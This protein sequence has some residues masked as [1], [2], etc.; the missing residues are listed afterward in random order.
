MPTAFIF[1]NY[2]HL[3]S[4]G[5]E[6]IGL[7]LVYGLRFD[8]PVILIFNL[9]F[10]FL[11]FS[12][13]SFRNANLY[14]LLLKII[15]M[16]INIPLI[17]FNLIDVFL[18]PFTL[19]RATT[20]E[21]Y[22][23]E[24]REPMDRISWSI[25][26]TYW[27]GLIVLFIFIYALGKIYSLVP[28]PKNEI[29]VGK[30]Q[31]LGW[32]ILTLFIFASCQGTFKAEP[33]SAVSASEIV[34]N[35][36]AAVILNTSYTFF[37]DRFRH[38]ESISEMNIEEAEKIY[39]AG[40]SFS[41]D[42]SLKKMNVVVIML[43]SFSAQYVGALYNGN[44]FTPFLDSLSNHSLLLTNCYSNGKVSIQGIPS[45]LSSIPSWG[46]SPFISSKYIHNRIKSFA[47]LLQPLGYSSAFFHGGKNGTM[48]FDIYAQAAGYQ[49]YY[50]WIDNLPQS[51]QRCFQ[52]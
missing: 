50:G 42:D 5:I 9:P 20:R 31:W 14:Q 49:K 51:F 2:R 41:K 47:S 19:S 32:S 15:F 21:L 45:V 11:H 10:I 37:F 8:I 24:S 33:V 18:Y 44:G 43:E 36:M 6:E 28:L 4:P 34:G 35:R 29:H 23:F 3:S 46:D 38:P 7:C 27:Y 22:I 52:Y 1:F 40:K 17:L 30:K 26:E 48:N 39:P 13:N 12:S 16:A 25:I